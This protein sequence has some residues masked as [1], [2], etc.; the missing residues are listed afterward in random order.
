MTRPLRHT[1]RYVVAGELSPGREVALTADDAHHLVRVVRREAGDT[2]ELIDAAGG[3]WEARVVALHPAVVRAEAPREAP[4]AAPVRLC[5][6][7]LDARGLDLVAEKATE[8][9][10]GEMVVATTSR[11]R[12]RPDSA[13]WTRRAARLDRVVAA[14]TR[15]C[16]RAGL[17]P[18]RG[19][20]PFE[21][22]VADTPAGTGFLIDPRG[23]APLAGA[24]RPP[25]EGGPPV[26]VAV[27]PEAGF[28]PQEVEAARSAGWL[29]CTLG[30]HILR[31]ET[32]AIAAATLAVA[33]AGHPG[34]E[35]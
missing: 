18:V 5:V 30:P 9:G 20:V 4:P 14:A 24:L 13:A 26:T 7:H 22:I 29:I 1:F 23:D 28:S 10:V 35:G 31:A 32:A 15:Q 21:A 11:L 2:V 27:G 33:A 6:G 12:R 19:L 34:A 16:G 3:L 25:R 8:L 17:M